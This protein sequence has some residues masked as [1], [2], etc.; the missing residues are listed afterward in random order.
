MLADTEHVP[1]VLSLKVDTLIF[2]PPIFHTPLMVH[3]GEGDR[4]SARVRAGPESD[5][6]TVLPRPDP[7]SM[8]SNRTGGGRSLKFGG[9][10]V[11]GDVCLNVPSRVQ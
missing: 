2:C 9:G 1:T 8:V 10:T 11:F 3:L 5:L 6:S 7:G 4:V